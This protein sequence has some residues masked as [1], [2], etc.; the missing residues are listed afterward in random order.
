MGGFEELGVV[1]GGEERKVVAEDT[2]QFGWVAC[3]VPGG[4]SFGKN[5]GKFMQFVGVTIRDPL[6]GIANG[7]NEG[8]KEGGESCLR[9]VAE[10]NTTIG[11]WEVGKEEGQGG[12]RGVG[13]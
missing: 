7:T 4:Q 10:T 12:E 5:W 2:D 13:V 8:D 9:V 11:E 3:G 6:G 1:G